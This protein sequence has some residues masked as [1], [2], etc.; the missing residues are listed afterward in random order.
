MRNA[1]L[2]ERVVGALDGLWVG[3]ADVGAIVGEMEGVVLGNAD[4]DADGV[5]L[6]T[7]VGVAVGLFVVPSVASFNTFNDEPRV[8]FRFLLTKNVVMNALATKT[9]TPRLAAIS[10]VLR[11]CGVI[12]CIGVL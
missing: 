7:L 11:L 4:G 8:P 10:M 3:V 2:D 1:K 9:N 12:V 5:W 6:G